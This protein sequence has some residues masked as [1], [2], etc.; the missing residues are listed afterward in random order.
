MWV[1]LALPY[2]KFIDI[3]ENLPN[4]ETQPKANGEQ[5]RQYNPW[6]KWYE[7]FDRDRQKTHGLVIKGRQSWD[8]LISRGP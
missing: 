4:Q 3:A 8:A 1:F 2:H 7:L 6:P 5:C